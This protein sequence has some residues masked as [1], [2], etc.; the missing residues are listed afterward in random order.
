MARSSLHV[1]DH[2]QRPTLHHLP[3]TFTSLH[4]LQKCLDLPHD[5]IGALDTVPMP[6]SLEHHHLLHLPF[7]RATLLQLRQSVKDLL[8]PFDASALVLTSCHD[9]HGA[10]DICVH[11]RF[12]VPDRDAVRYVTGYFLAKDHL[13]DK[14]LLTRSRSAAGGRDRDRVSHRIHA[15]GFDFCYASV[16]GSGDLGCRVHGPDEDA[17]FDKGAVRWTG[18][19]SSRDHAA[20]G[21]AYDD[22][23]L[24]GEVFEEGDDV[25]SDA[26]DRGCG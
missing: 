25:G 13:A 4:A 1:L 6:H 23:G 19:D 9:Q 20:H 14:C 26:L 18:G 12:G 3:Q 24:Y 10:F 5:L 2:L 11:G 7:L 22:G 8:T 16:E 15:L 17:G 21:V